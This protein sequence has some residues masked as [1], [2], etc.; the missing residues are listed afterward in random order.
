MEDT[1]SYIFF[2]QI[3]K[4]KVPDHEETI[5]LARLAKAGDIAA[6]NRLVEGNLKFVSKIAISYKGKGLP[7]P[8][9]INEGSIGLITAT[10]RFDPESGN[11]FLTYAKFWI[12][13]AISCALKEK[14][15]IIRIP[16]NKVEKLIKI[17]KCKDELESSKD[18]DV[19]AQEI[20]SACGIDRN[21]VEYCLSIREDATSLDIPLQGVKEKTLLDT[22][23]SNYPGP[24]KCALD[25]DFIT[26]IEGIL[27]SLPERHR[28]IIVR[29]YGLFNTKAQ[30]LDDVSKAYGIT[31]ERVR[32]IENAAIKML[33]TNPRSEELRVYLNAS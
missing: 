20:S 31:R 2:N 4:T 21:E 17:L 12:H 13:Q 9:L 10:E 22:V 3:Q 11:S 24:E 14:A 29:R 6:R 8:D 5:R 26:Q 1:S 23:E 25:S 33:K 28:D 16:S 19:T 32:Q 30:S 18:D 27:S 15:R 7:L